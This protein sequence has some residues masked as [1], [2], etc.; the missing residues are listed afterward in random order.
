MPKVMRPQIK[1]GDVVRISKKGLKISLYRRIADKTLVVVEIKFGDGIDKYSRVKCMVESA[2]RHEFHTIGRPYLWRTGYNIN[3]LS[4][5]HQMTT[6]EGRDW[7]A[8][9]KAANGIKDKPKSG[10]KCSC[11]WPLVY[12]Q[13]CQCGGV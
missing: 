11:P 8:K 3:D 4:P 12:A 10:K 5:A 7:E 2:D 13:G 6:P 9:W 1:V